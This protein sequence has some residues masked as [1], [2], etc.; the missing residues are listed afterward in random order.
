LT[1]QQQNRFFQ[2]LP[3]KENLSKLP[4]FFFFFY[5]KYFFLKMRFL[6]AI[7]VLGLAIQAY[8]Q[9]P[10]PSVSLS[11]TI[12]QPAAPSAPVNK[13]L[14]HII[15]ICPT[16]TDTTVNQKLNNF[17]VYYAE[18]GTGIVNF[19]LTNQLSTVITNLNP[20]VL[21]DVWVQGVDTNVGVFSA[22]SSITV[23]QTDPA[24]PKL[25]PSLDISG[26]TCVQ[27]ANPRSDPVGRIGIQCSW[28]A[29]AATS[30]NTVQQINIKCQCTSATREDVFIRKTLFGTRAT[31]TSFFLA[32][33]R[34]DANCN[35]FARFYYSRRPTTRHFVNVVLSA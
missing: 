22:N 24:D 20:G 17:R 21:Y 14:N 6:L 8:S 28:T 32:V 13:C 16:W 31:A 4:S 27:A 10:S 19:V 33:N 34:D 3:F 2:T 26:F 18:Q 35:V 12:P 11:Q 23:M 7:L 1:L 29:P 30:T 5:Y 25:D 15:T 9:T